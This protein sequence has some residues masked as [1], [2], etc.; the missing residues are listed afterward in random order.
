M[1]SNLAFVVA[2]AA[3]VAYIINIILSLARNHA[4]ARK[5]GFPI[6]VSLIDP[7]NALWILTKPLLLPLLALLPGDAGKNSRLSS[8]G[9]QFKAKN[10]VHER[11]GKIFIQVTPSCNIINIADHEISY[12]VMQNIEDFVK[13]RKSY[14]KYRPISSLASYCLLNDIPTSLTTRTRC[15]SCTK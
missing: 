7:T 12:N 15:V 5:T 13:P 14:R 9:W 3:A 6:V 4:I 11:L 1:L 2:F 10:T 8:F